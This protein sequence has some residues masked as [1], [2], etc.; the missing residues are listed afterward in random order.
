MLS[1][2]FRICR[3]TTPGPDTPT[4]IPKPLSP[5]TGTLNIT[6]PLTGPPTPPAQYKVACTEAGSTTPLIFTI[7]ADADGNAIKDPVEGLKP[8]TKYV[9]KVIGQD[10][11]G[12]DVTP[13]SVEVE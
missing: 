11:S 6:K 8:G 12:K 9:V 5:T 13:Q 7:P 4:V 10:A 3:C 2:F 1:F